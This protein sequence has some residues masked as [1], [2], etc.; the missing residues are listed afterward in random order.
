MAQRI[1]PRIEI[2]QVVLHRL[3]TCTTAFYETFS[4]KVA[5][6][7]ARRT[8]FVYT[9]RQAPCRPCQFPSS[10]TLSFVTMQAPNVGTR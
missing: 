4:A 8:E 7:L 2:M 9:R 10:W 6:K 1:Y 5:R 3:W